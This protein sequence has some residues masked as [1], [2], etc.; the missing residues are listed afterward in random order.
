MSTAA[1]NARREAWPWFGHNS[2]KFF[3]LLFVINAVPSRWY[4]P[5]STYSSTVLTLFMLLLF[6]ASNHHDRH[7]CERCIAAWPLDPQKEIEKHDLAFRQIHSFENVMPN[8]TPRTVRW[9]KWLVAAVFVGVYL[10]I[11]AGVRWL[12]PDWGTDVLRAIINLILLPWIFWILYQ[13]HRL[14]AWCPYCRSGGTGEY[15]FDPDPIPTRK[16]KV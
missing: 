4:A 3:I 12:L 1:S 13:H 9:G 14:Q 8:F 10:L 7:I 6:V 11:A 5:V 2:W 15:S 16:V